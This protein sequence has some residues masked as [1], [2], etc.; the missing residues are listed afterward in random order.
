MNSG[1]VSWGDVESTKPVEPKTVTEI[2]TSCQDGVCSAT[3]VSDYAGYSKTRHV[4]FEN[5][6]GKQS[7]AISYV[8]ADPAS[9]DYADGVEYLKNKYRTS[10]VPTSSATG[11]TS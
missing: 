1:Y 2:P 8:S 9:K 7:Y 6:A 4:W 3:F 10:G 5:S 11:T